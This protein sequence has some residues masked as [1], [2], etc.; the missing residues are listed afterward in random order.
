M[1]AAADQYGMLYAGG[2]D[3]SGITE[4]LFGIVGV[5]LI[6]SAAKQLLGVCKGYRS[7]GNT[8]IGIFIVF[9][10]LSPVVSA[11]WHEENILSIDLQTDFDRIAQDA[12]IYRQQ[13]MRQSITDRT[14]AYIWT[15][16]QE[17]SLD[18]D[19]EITLNEAY[20]YAPSKICI[21]GAVSPYAKAQLSNYLEDEIG[22]PKEAQ[23]WMPARP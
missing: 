23:T 18:I 20:P 11:N 10:I 13:A 22:I 14:K 19:L 1:L 8:V 2:G 9:S 16:A 6:A 4:Y 15:K 3:L 17:L 5:C 12:D 7:L 21:M